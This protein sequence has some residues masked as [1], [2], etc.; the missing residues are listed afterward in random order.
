MTVA[1]VELLEVVDVNHQK[2][3]RRGVCA[4]RLLQQVIE[5]PA[6][7]DVRKR[8]GFSLMTDIVEIGP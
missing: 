3:E 1:V 2:R 7:S 4:Y 5:G 8:I 6:V